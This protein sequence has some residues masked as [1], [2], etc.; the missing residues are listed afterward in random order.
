MLR[1]ETHAFPDALLHPET[2]AFSDAC[3]NLIGAHS[4]HVLSPP[5]ACQNLGG[6][7]EVYTAIFS[8]TIQPTGQPTKFA[9]RATDFSVRVV[10][11]FNCLTF[12]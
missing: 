12:L 4:S 6:Q 10:Q 2:H 8:S 9:L 5:T 3:V 11:N 1:L 7:V